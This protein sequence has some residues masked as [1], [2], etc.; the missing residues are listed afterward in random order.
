[1]AK[2][3][4]EP[5]RSVHFGTERVAEHRFCNNRVRTTLYVRGW[6]TPFI[7]FFKGVIIEEFAKLPKRYFA[8][9]VALQSWMSW[10]GDEG[11]W[12]LWLGVR[13]V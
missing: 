8:F 1:M 10:C 6:L 5:F 7:F 13:Y 12:W 9:I 4:T 11:L 3:K 2:K